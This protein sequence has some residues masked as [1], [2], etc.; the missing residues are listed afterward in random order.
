MPK[1]TRENDPFS[2]VGIKPFLG[3]I[4]NCCGIYIISPKVGLKIL[5]YINCS[6]LQGFLPPRNVVSEHT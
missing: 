3:V 5:Y 6:V 4:K 1:K 2:L